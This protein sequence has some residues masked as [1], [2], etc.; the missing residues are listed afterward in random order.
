VRAKFHTNSVALGIPLHVTLLYPFAPPDQ[1]DEAALTGFFAQRDPMTIAL[2]GVAEWPGVVYAVPEPHEELLELTSA[3]WARF[4]DY[5]PYGGEIAEPRPHAT[6]AEPGPR[7]SAE[8]AAAIRGR[9]ASVFPL[10][11]HVDDVAVLEEDAPGR[12][13][14][15]RRF[16]LRRLIG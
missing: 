4:P 6:L 15:R 2:V 12:W 7:E 5:P 14:E 16:P 1:V 3:L 8:V 10:A 9:T 11:C 13:R